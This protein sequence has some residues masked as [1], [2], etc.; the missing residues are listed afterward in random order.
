VNQLTP[1]KA[2]ENLAAISEPTHQ[3][4]NQSGAIAIQSLMVLTELL[5]KSP[6][7]PSDKAKKD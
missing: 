3:H 7:K 6:E 5:D 4:T 2:L 1:E